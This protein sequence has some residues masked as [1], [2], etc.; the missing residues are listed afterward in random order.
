MNKSQTYEVRIAGN[1]QDITEKATKVKKTLE[2]L[3]QNSNAP[4][5]ITKSFEK[6][7]S[8]LGLI[9]QK[10]SKKLDLDGFKDLNHDVGSIKKVLLSL[11]ATFD[12][13]YQKNEKEKLQL[14]DPE[15]LKKIQDAQKGVLDLEKALKRISKEGKTL[16]EARGALEKASLEKEARSS[17]VQSKKGERD[18]TQRK[19]DDLD[20]ADSAL[21]KRIEEFKQAEED[22]SQ[23]EKALEE[24]SKG[25]KRTKQYKD[26]KKGVDTAKANK[27]A[28]ALTEAETKAIEKNKI[29]REELTA[30]LEEQNKAY[31]KA[32]GSLKRAIEAEEAAQTKLALAEESD[33]T[34]K[35]RE[36]EQAYGELYTSLSKLIPNFDEL[37]ISADYSEDNVQKLNQAVN[38]FKE[39]SITDLNKQLK[40]AIDGFDEMGNMADSATDSIKSSV[41]T[42]QA[43]NEVAS[44]VE[45][46]KDRIKQFLGV[47]GAVQ[48][49]QR[50]SRDA[51]A[52]ISELDETM[53]EMAVVTELSVGDY[54]NQLPEYS[55]QA[56]D[57]GVSI[58]S[59]YKAATLYYQQGLK[60]NEVTKISAETLKMAKIANLDAAEATD[61]MT[62]A[63]RGFNMELNETSAQRVSDVYSQL[64]AITAA[65]TKE[66]ANAM[67]KTASIAS[68]AGMEFETTA[69]FLSQIIETTRES[70]ETAGTALKTVIARFQELKKDPSEIGEIDGEI[71]DANAIETALRSVGVALRDSSGQF[72]ELDDVFLDLSSKWDGLDKNTQRYIATIAA[73]SRQ[74]S[75][76]IAMMSNYG[77]TQ[78][79]VT[80]ANNSAGASQKQFE[81]TTESLEYKIEKLKNAWHEFTMGIMNSDFVKFGVDILN[82]FLEVLNKATSAMGGFGNS[83]AKISTIFAVFQMGSKI[84]KKLTPHIDNVLTKIVKKFY[85]YGEAAA[86]NFKEGM[87]GQEK[88]TTQGELTEEQ[89]KKKEKKLAITREALKKGATSELVGFKGA[90]KKVA[91]VAK[92]YVGKKASKV[93]ETVG[94]IG[95]KFTQFKDERKKFS[96]GKED[97]SKKRDA[98][99]QEIAN[100]ELIISLQG[101]VAGFEEETEKAK[102][103]LSELRA[104]LDKLDAEV[105]SSAQNYKDQRKKQASELGRNVASKLGFGEAISSHDKAAAARQEASDLA[106]KMPELENAEQQA[107]T[108]YDTD[109]QKL[110][111]FNNRNSKKMQ[112]LSATE[113]DRQEQ[114]SSLE[115]GESDRKVKIDMLTRQAQF[116][117]ESFNESQEKTLKTLQK[118]QDQL[119][120]LRKEQGQLVSLREKEEKLTKKAQKSQQKYEEAAKE[121]TENEEAFNEKSEEYL[122][123]QEKMWDDIGKGVS[124]AGEKI[125]GVGVAASMLGGIFDQL[126]LEGLGEAFSTLG[127]VATV[128]GTA[129]SMLGPI[130]SM[131][132]KIGI[133][134]A[135]KLTIA[136]IQTQMAWWWI[137]IIVAA[138][139]ALLIIAIAIAKAVKN[140][141]AKAQLDKAREAADAAAEAADAA[142]ESYENLANALDGLDD[143][144]QA[145]EELTRGTEEWNEAV[146]DINNSVLDLIQQY[147][148]LAKFVK[149]EGGVLTLDVNT[150]EVQAILNDYQKNAVIASNVA[151]G[152]KINVQEKEKDYATDQLAD[153]LKGSGM[154]GVRNAENYGKALADGVIAQTGPGAF[155]IIEGQE[156]VAEQLGITETALKM[157]G[158]YIE[159]DVDALREYG[160][161]LQQADEQTKALYEAMALQAQQLVDMS[162]WTDQQRNQA[163]NLVTGEDV[164]RYEDEFKEQ[165]SAD[166]SNDDNATNQELIKYMESLDG[167]SSVKNVRADKIAYIDDKGEKQVVDKE[168][169]LKQMY[170]AKATEKAASAIS[171]SRTVASSTAKTINDKIS[172]Q[173]ETTRKAMGSAMGRLFEDS[174]GS[175][176]TKAD[177]D[178]LSKL[179]DEEL[180]EIYNST[181]E[182]QSLFA[183]AEDF[184][185]S[186]RDTLRKSDETAA[187]AKII[188]DEINKGLEQKI[189]ITKEFMNAGQ[190]KAFAK[191]MSEVFKKTGSEGAA[192]LVAEFDGVLANKT[193]EEKQKIT[194]LVNSYD[195]SNL[196]EVR[197]MQRDLVNSFD[198]GTEEAKKFADAVINYNNA[199]SS[200]ATQINPFDEYAQSLQ[201][202]DT[203]ERKITDLQWEYNEA[204]RDGTAAMTGMLDSLYEQIIAA[205]QA[206]FEKA[207]EAKQGADK[208]LATAYASGANIEGVGDLREIIPLLQDA[209]G[210]FS[211]DTSNIDM[212]LANNEKVQEWIEK[213]NEQIEAGEEAEDLAREAKEGILELDDTAK[214]SRKELRDAIKDTLLNGLQEQI[215]VSREILEAEKE[216]NAQL[217]SKMQE[218]IN[219]QRQRDQNAETEQNI[220]DMYSQLAYMQMDTGSSPLEAAQLQEQIANA[221]KEYQNTLIDQ[222]IQS[223]QDANAKAEEQRERQISLQEQ[224]LENY[225]N[226]EQFQA[227]VESAL[228]EMLSSNNPFETAIG[229]Q[230]RDS[231]K[232]GLTADELSDWEASMA[233]TVAQAK[234][235]SNLEEILS[236]MEMG[237]GMTLEEIEARAQNAADTQK[238]SDLASKGFNLLTTE[239]ATEGSFAHGS[240]VV[241]AAENLTK[242]DSASQNADYQATLERAKK[243]G[244]YSKDI[245]SEYDYY[246]GMD[247]S[248][249][250]ADGAKSYTE[251]LAS[252]V[253]EVGEFENLTAEKAFG[254]ISVPGSYSGILDMWGN[255][256]F[257]TNENFDATVNGETDNYVRLGDKVSNDS[258]IKRLDYIYNNTGSSNTPY[259]YYNDMLYLRQGA[260]TWWIVKNESDEDYPRR[261]RDSAK[262]YMNSKTDKIYTKYAYKTGG[263][264]DFTGP[265]W[266]DGTPSKPEYI[267]NAKQTER[268]FSLVDVL[269][270]FND[271]EGKQAS[272]DNYFDISINVEK[273]E[274]DYDVE[275]I[276]DK[277]RRMIYEDA[278]YR[279]VNT[280]N[281][282]R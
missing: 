275:K 61:K 127:Q 106:K 133:S 144:Y 85:G 53:T 184:A 241:S 155:K 188:S 258:L 235:I 244:N 93:K 38:S 171:A 58:N 111:N 23:A 280:I 232:L 237:E 83:I 82:V 146:K 143:K 167:V 172:S 25:D 194:D 51:I 40:V 157:Y 207:K 21:L 1:I 247:A 64:A 79:L 185:A 221:E 240:N 8:L 249:I 75:R 222:S 161:S 212:G 183:S 267:L 117:P 245:L 248:E 210:N 48:V 105:A 214:E 18:Q 66:I 229:S 151:V 22:L 279:N 234:G 130:I 62:A 78:E 43:Q 42:I 20:A 191:K 138:V 52:T 261:L 57:L 76:F 228:N 26:A 193:K 103:T 277:I 94:G 205:N 7:D 198:I 135:G 262:N 4:A 35:I 60:G 181:S 10:A 110:T 71:V 34:R 81:K 209:E 178:N 139:A 156:A 9:R 260:G 80:A 2:G 141:S 174:D 187:E 197:A 32:Q 200:F 219:V 99:Q 24:A 45:G 189:D 116:R 54:W 163:N 148:E 201:E 126:G 74:Q 202:L 6:L 223:L 230:M 104:D 153:N 5:G 125:T 165:Y 134:T 227:S 263:L 231:A 264:A 84:F 11:G 186:T 213:V 147:P 73:G 86:K 266:L 70:A 3:M 97:N 88:K 47:A 98:I 145:L 140:N 278:S 118:E 115:T 233:V 257:V 246:S 120:N 182:L 30:T 114:I 169:Y 107:K 179:T 69:A 274:N 19:L 90:P 162:N 224:S 253:G 108:T 238:R 192:G 122:T 242:K 173:D 101:G 128:F 129:L 92:E 31:E 164:K 256:Q 211:L 65:D 254:G 36:Q 226:S 72:R 95:K 259:T 136:G 225:K 177:V 268:F 121:R 102:K 270:H 239:G 160:E 204:M 119:E 142:K 100:Q 137:L 44:R 14:L 124:A 154:Y 180:K 152:A 89:K 55:K 218:Q 28:K 63:L 250:T 208:R 281:H 271:K 109:T 39:N 175:K 29:A 220:T 190:Q 41:S 27:N 17:F 255:P 77:R 56:S 132:G 216:A 16:K 150:S 168:T 195:W 46:L 13:L 131:V 252:E 176:L 91:G 49:F 273:L 12:D 158:S 196:E 272:G 149:N 33:A 236:G 282:I 123:N 68:S 113:G 243:S 112:Q 96:E 170:S 206:K 276:A 217:I 199:L 203:I 59:A 159:K 215:D 251:Y 37:G 166:S 87:E 67:T 50:A 269:E 15:D 265:A